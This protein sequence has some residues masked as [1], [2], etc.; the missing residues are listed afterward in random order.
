[1][2]ASP[3]LPRKC[4]INGSPFS[5]FDINETARLRRAEL[6]ASI[7][8]ARLNAMRVNVADLF[9]V[10]AEAAPELLPDAWQPV[11]EAL[12]ANKRFW[13]FPDA[14]LGDIEE[15]NPNA[16]MSPFIN[17]P[18]VIREWDTLVT[19]A[20][21]AKRTLPSDAHGPS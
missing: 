7:L 9:L 15:G 10:L 5:D 1:M 3:C 8:A 16:L 13:V 6:E 19:L 4:C 14:T 21:E 18:R 17:R 20:Y 12:V 11:H 2:E